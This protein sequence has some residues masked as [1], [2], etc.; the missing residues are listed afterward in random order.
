MNV[1]SEFVRGDKNA[2]SAYDTRQHCGWVAYTTDMPVV[3]AERL[4]G[5]SMCRHVI[6][7]YIEGAHL[8]PDP[9]WTGAGTGGSSESQDRV[10]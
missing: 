5:I 7:R 4:R 3:G 2:V 1:N 10:L 6:C 9:I 8:G